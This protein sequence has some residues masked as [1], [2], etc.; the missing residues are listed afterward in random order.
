[1]KRAFCVAALVL[2]MCWTS[3]AQTN[4][5][6]SPASKEDIQRYLDAV[7]SHDMM[8][9]VVTAMTQG[10]HSMW[11]EQFLKHKDELPVDYETKMNARMDDM[12]QNMPFDEMMQAA[13]P[14]YQKHLTK[15]DVDNLVAFYASPT[16][17]KMLRE[18]P[19]IMAESMQSMMPV[20]TKYMEKVQQRLQKDTE[21]MIAESKKKAGE[22]SATQN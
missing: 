15:G 22:K 3:L 1:M 12:L 17:A 5:A 21:T 18:M 14:V 16:G 6:D 20:M 19:D 13:A 11:H 2:M 8:K 4:A 9:K 10:M 7:H